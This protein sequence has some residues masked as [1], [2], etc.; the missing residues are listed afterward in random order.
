MKLFKFGLMALFISTSAYTQEIMPDVIT[1]TISQSTTMT[2]SEIKAQK[3]DFIDFI[4]KYKNS[5]FIGH[6]QYALSAL[7]LSIRANAKYS[8]ETDG[9]VLF[10][11]A[12][13]G[14]KLVTAGDVTFPMQGSVYFEVKNKAGAATEFMTED[15]E[16]I[17]LVAKKNT[18]YI[19]ES[20]KSFNLRKNVQSKFNRADKP[21]GRFLGITRF[22]LF[23]QDVEFYE[24]QNGRE[25]LRRGSFNGN[26]APR[27]TNW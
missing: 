4:T 1:D 21:I 18:F 25:L 7:N 6:T 5:E 11:L 10:Q 9:T 26:A 12:T 13:A 20:E 24:I 23:S 17:N 8:I 2:P 15:G 27:R 16:I 22:D 3:K 14:N 19:I